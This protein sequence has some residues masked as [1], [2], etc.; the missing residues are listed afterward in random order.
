MGVIDALE[1]SVQRLAKNSHCYCVLSGLPLI[2]K[3]DPLVFAPS[4]SNLNMEST[5]LFGYSNLILS[6]V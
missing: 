2:H 1:N 3:E 6:S 5:C 4:V